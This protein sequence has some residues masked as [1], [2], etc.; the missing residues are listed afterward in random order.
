MALHVE[1]RSADAWQR[2][3]RWQDWCVIVRQ[4]PCRRLT[5]QYS[6][7]YYR[8]TYI[9]TAFDAGFASAMAIRPKWLKDICSVVFSAYYLLWASEGDEVASDPKFVARWPKL[10]T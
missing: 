8:A 3:N 4:R 2:R 1:S 9:N 5:R 10:M 6:R 7:S